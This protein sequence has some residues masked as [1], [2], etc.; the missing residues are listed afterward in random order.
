MIRRLA[1]LALVAGA[2]IPEEGPMMEPGQDCM[3]CHGGGAGGDEGDDARPWTVA[4]T[5][6]PSAAT[7]DAGAGVRGATISIRDAGGKSFDLRSNRA[8]NFYSAEPLAFPIAVSVNGSPMDA[9]VLAGQGSCNR[10]H[11]LGD[12]GRIPA[13]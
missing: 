4:G 9:P 11:R 12:A 2:C 5:V 7:A 3:E 8:G 10:C 1:A 6:Y 13:G